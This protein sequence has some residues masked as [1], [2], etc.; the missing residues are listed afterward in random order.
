LLSNSNADVS[1]PEELAQI[2]LAQ[3]SPVTVYKEGEP[4]NV[5]LRE[6]LGEKAR[7]VAV[8]FLPVASES[9][10]LVC[11]S[12]RSGG[13]TPDDIG[14]ASRFALILKQAL[15][16][17]DEQDK[18]MQS[19][20]L[21]AL[22]QMSASLAHEL[23]QPLNTI[24]ATAQNLEMMA[25][26][27]P[28]AV[29]ILAQKISRILGQVDRASQIMDRIR[30]FSRKSG[31]VFA[32]ADLTAL[33][34]GVRLLMEPAAMMGRVQL[35]VDVEPGLSVRCDG[36]QV[37]QVLANLVRNALDALAGIGSAHKTENGAI[38]IRGYRTASG[39]AIRVEDNG[40]GFPA[41]VT[42]RPL[43]TFFTTKSAEAGTGLG[44][45]ICHMIARAHA[46]RL[47]LG[48]H[49]GGGYV[50][51]HLPERSDDAR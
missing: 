23:R 7:D 41:D 42:S 12:R 13:F 44:L 45:S 26:N 47:E 27:G 25:E 8:I 11:A 31:G 18:L 3:L 21:S 15:V 43:E 16:L 24:N 17:K 32:P 35:T 49:A 37:E 30:R 22:G 40:P 51:L 9:I 20:K 34:D 19:G 48:N 5:A 1:G 38:S 6:L 14:L 39:V 4:H 50:E 10:A 46:G 36:V 29:E 33:A 28:V 2:F